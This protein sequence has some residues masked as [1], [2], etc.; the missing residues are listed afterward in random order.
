MPTIP[1]MMLPKLPKVPQAAEAIKDAIKQELVA[2]GIIANNIK[3]HPSWN[4]IYKCWEYIATYQRQPDR[5]IRFRIFDEKSDTKQTGE[6]YINR[7]NNLAKSG[8]DL[9]QQLL[10]APEFA[11]VKK[12][13]INKINKFNNSFKDRLRDL[14]PADPRQHEMAIEIFQQLNSEIARIL[15]EIHVEQDFSARLQDLGYINSKTD[16][17]CKR[18]APIKP[19]EWLKILEQHESRYTATIKRDL[20]VHI[21]KSPGLSDTWTAN[22]NVPYSDLPSTLRNGQD[23][24]LPNWFRSVTKIFKVNTDTKSPEEINSFEAERSTSFSA[25]AANKEERAKINKEIAANKLRVLVREKIIEKLKS[26]QEW[27]ELF[28]QMPACFK[29]KMLIMTLL[30]LPFRHKTENKFMSEAFSESPQFLDTIKAFDDCQQERLMLLPEDLKYILNHVPEI[31]SNIPLLE[32]LSNTPIRCETV[33][34]NFASSGLRS[35]SKQNNYNNI[36]LKSMVT[37][38]GE[39]LKKNH[40]T[41]DSNNLKNLEELKEIY[42]NTNDQKIKNTISLYI[43]YLELLKEN[44]NE[45]GDNFLRQTITALLV[46]HLGHEL[47]VTCKSGEDRTG[48]NF[49]AIECALARVADDVAKIGTDHGAWQE[50]KKNFWSNYIATEKLS[51]SREI[52]NMNAIGARGLQSQGEAKG[53][54]KALQKLRIL[55]RQISPIAAGL[56]VS[57][58]M[59]RISKLAFKKYIPHNKSRKLFKK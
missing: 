16:R 12:E 23:R 41:F 58:K 27:S 35:L 19:E 15:H 34:H 14:D 39:Y 48:A 10:N 4:D 36:A 52:T 56:N 25:I 46:N 49:V 3:L 37:W 47:H 11:S 57:N 54:V 31:K 29:Q 55:L 28:K 38:F 5:V 24:I 32:L 18:P 7:S 6:D 9:I 13:F 21:Y 22:Y 30:N 42:G 33:F 45:P 51:A 53:L 40:I 26:N 44:S 50:F 2:K 43:K 20:L 59:A 1:L 8:I 17:K